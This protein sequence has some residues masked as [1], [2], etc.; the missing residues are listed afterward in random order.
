MNE[1]IT[2]T[3][4]SIATVTTEIRTIT[5]QAQSMILQYAVEIGTRLIEAKELVPYGEWGEYLKNEVEFSQSTAN[6]FMRLA[7]EYGEAGGLFGNAANLQALGNLSYT[8]A[9]RLLAIPAEERQEFAEEH[10][11]EDLSTRELDK[12]IKQVE[13]EKA[14]KAKLQEAL[15]TSVDANAKKAAELE[16]AAEN[17]G[18]EAAAAKKQVEM[19]AEQL[20]KAKKA[21]KKAKAEAEKLKASPEIPETIMEQLRRDAEAEAAKSAR[22]EA[23]ARV[24]DAQ[25]A[26]EKAAREK[27]EAEAK[28]AAAQK[29]NQLANPDVAVF[30]ALFQQVQ[31]D[32]N[33]LQGVLLKV[34]AQDPAMAGKLRAAMKALIDKLGKEAM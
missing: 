22:A 19:L 16:A 6:N 27:A 23:E 10:K 17:A 1:M 30:Q 11:V 25:A 5:K 26:A 8:Q 33:R 28:L 13:E 21:E 20:E 32:F 4:R 2:T 34:E 18:R 7:K 29:A 14:A 12:L 24:K 31:Q 9:L 3:G 15:R